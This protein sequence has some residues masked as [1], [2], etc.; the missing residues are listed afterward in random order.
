M[1]NPVHWPGRALALPVRLMAMGLSAVVSF[2]VP[3]PVVAGA[4]PWSEPA[5]RSLFAHAE[6][7]QLI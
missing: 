1:L 5:E 7:N 3:K 2:F 6:D 4:R